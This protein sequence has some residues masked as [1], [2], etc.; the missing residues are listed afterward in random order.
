[1]DYRKAVRAR[2]GSI[3]FVGMPGVDEMTA[4]VP[5]GALFVQPRVSE[6]H[7]R[8]ESFD[9]PEESPATQE[10][11]DALAEHS[12]LVLLGDPGAGKSTLVNWIALSLCQAGG[13]GLLEQTLGR[14]YVPL[15]L[16]LR[17]LN[18]P[19]VPSWRDLMGAFLETEPAVVF[20]EKPKLLHDLLKIGQAFLILDGYDELGD[21]VRREAI[22]EALWEGLTL[23]P[24]CRW[25]I[26]SRVI[27][28][29]EAVLERLEVLES[30]QDPAELL[31]KARV[32]AAEEA[33]HKVEKTEEQGVRVRFAALRYL[34][35]MN[36][37]QI[38]KFSQQWWKYNSDDP[39]F[40]NPSAFLG[41]LRA[42]AG[43]K[44]LSRNPTLLTL[45]C[46]FF[47]S[48]G[49]L[50]DN[51]F[52]LYKK[53]CETYL[54]SIDKVRRTVNQLD[55]FQYSVGE[56]MGW[57]AEIALSMQVGG[58]MVGNAL[59][60]STS[61]SHLLTR[62]EWLTKLEGVIKPRGK[63]SARG[64]AE[65]F[66][67]SLHRRS[68]LIAAA[69]LSEQRERYAFVHPSFQEFFA[70]YKLAYLWTDPDWLEL[71]E[72]KEE[73]ASTVGSRQWFKPVAQRSRMREMFV[74][75][76][77]G[78]GCV[79]QKF[80]LRILKRL[81][82]KAGM[83]DW[84]DFAGTGLIAEV[85]RM[86]I[87]QGHATPDERT[88][89]VEVFA[90]LAINPYV[91][92][93]GVVT[94]EGNFR[95]LLLKHCWRF[96]LAHYRILDEVRLHPGDY[97]G[98][99]KLLFARPNQIALDVL[100]K[101]LPFCPALTQLNLS[102]CAGLTRLPALPK[103]SKVRRVIVYKCP[104]LSN[105]EVRRFKEECSS[106]LGRHV[107]VEVVRGARKSAG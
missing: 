23:H 16:V 74:F 18:L 51:R 14:A 42:S 103:G 10:I 61:N 104:N 35:P 84:D 90:A 60:P 83:V 39:R 47:L 85:R 38:E 106:V 105:E 58:R 54:R 34:A 15:V 96:Q 33:G 92:F 50:P 80:P 28:Y 70:G 44:I 98:V 45:C 46:C 97:L 94:L 48:E 8:P 7:L 20:R 17:E 5:L 29:D 9:D 57:I 68:G 12:R 69:G 95:E 62:G 59:L 65:N 81:L 86:P 87:V 26:T 93:D 24:H 53:I 56:Q 37:G 21:R 88:S 78:A 1:L 25:L 19:K 31:G 22:R 75:A 71:E 40:K 102:H 3:S 30:K 82:G 41:S 63:D 32:K 4:K 49:G 107:N 66:F 99:A 55:D 6:D 101:Q 13:D 2:H 27:G 91:T 73:D 43:T 64:V 67:D 89:F 76:W 79:H 72:D 52:P 100:T 36:D 11:A 77:E